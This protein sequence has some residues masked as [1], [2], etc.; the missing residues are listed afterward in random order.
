MCLLNRVLT[1]SRTPVINTS[2]MKFVIASPSKGMNALTRTKIAILI[3]SLL[4]VL[5]ALLCLSNTQ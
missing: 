3:N 1:P 4:I 2:V 5:I